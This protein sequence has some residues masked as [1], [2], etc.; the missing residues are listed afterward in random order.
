MLAAR[1]RSALRRAA[2]ASR[3]RCSTACCP[4]RCRRRPGSTV[5]R[6]YIA[7]VDDVDIGGDWYDVMQLDDGDVLFVVGTCRAGASRAATI[8]ASLR[9]AI[10]AYAAQGDDPTTILTKLAELI[11]VGDSGH[12]ATVLC[13]VIDV[14]RH[15]VTLANAAHPEPLLVD[16]DQARFVST[17]VGVPIGVEHS[18]PYA[19][20]TLTVPPASSSRCRAGPGWRRAVRAR[21]ARISPRPR[22]RAR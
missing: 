2:H 6:R 7:G 18:R 15:T 12:F 16:T 9:Y 3:R 22:P 17:D 8:M 4:R 21:T 14:E 10:R 1:E 11:D 19:S 20:V 13:G 5:G